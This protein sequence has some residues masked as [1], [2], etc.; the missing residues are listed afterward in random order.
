MSDGISFVQAIDCLV[1]RYQ[2]NTSRNYII[3]LMRYL[4]TLSARTDHL[5]LC[6]SICKLS[7]LCLSSVLMNIIFH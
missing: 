3:S 6:I 4:I 7:L 5:M 2:F 1:I